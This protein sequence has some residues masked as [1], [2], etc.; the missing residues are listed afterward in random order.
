MAGRKRSGKVRWSEGKK[1][2]R[3]EGERILGEGLLE[4]RK[5]GEYKE[6]RIKGVR[7]RL[8]RISWHGGSEGRCFKGSEKG[9]WNGGRRRRH[10]G[11][12]LLE[13]DAFEWRKGKSGKGILKKRRKEGKV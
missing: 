8:E 13:R 6:R 11:R 3:C 2:G 12:R 9:S 7:R 10:K 4:W 5:R 1:R